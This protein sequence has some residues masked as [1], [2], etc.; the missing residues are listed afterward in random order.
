MKGRTPPPQAPRFPPVM[1]LQARTK[2]DAYAEA[3]E[4]ARQGM[5][6]LWI[7]QTLHDDGCRAVLS[8]ADDDCVAPCQPDF[9]L[10]RY[11]AHANFMQFDQRMRKAGLN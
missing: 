7:I 5:I 8:H 11:D 2:D 9:V 4:Y 10:M 1:R 3:A 6:G